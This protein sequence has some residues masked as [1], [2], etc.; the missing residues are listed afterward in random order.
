MGLLDVWMLAIN[1]HDKLVIKMQ[2]CL[3]HDQSLDPPMRKALWS[4]AQNDRR[5]MSTKFP[6]VK[7]EVE[8]RRD[9]IDFVSDVVPP[10]GPPLAWVLLW[11]GKYANIYGAYVP[12]SLRQWG[13]VIW[14]ERRWIDMGAKE[15]IARQWE[16]VPELVKEMEL[17]YDWSP[18]GSRNMTVIYE[19]HP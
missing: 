12:E 3:T 19:C 2:R 13:Y 11:G 10:D 7:D 5:E 15:L 8:Q 9:P 18:I 4:V 17:D 6:Q 14:D 1:N 16:T